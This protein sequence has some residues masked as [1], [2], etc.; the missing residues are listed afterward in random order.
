MTGNIKGYRK[1]HDDDCLWSY[2]LPTGGV[3]FWYCSCG[4]SN[5][6]EEQYDL[7]YDAG[8]RCSSPLLGY[9]PDVGPRCRL[10]GT[11]AHIEYF[12]DK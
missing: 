9:R 5:W 4:Y 2:P 10:C 8:C 6:E 3:N 7:L 12:K 1:W 11:V